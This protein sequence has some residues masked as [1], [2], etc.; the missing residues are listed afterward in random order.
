MKPR[1]I[2]L[3]I[4]IR[5]AG[6]LVFLLIV[7]C[8]CAFG[9]AGPANDNFSSRMTLTGTNVAITGSNVEATRE[10]GDTSVWWSWTAPT[11]AT[12]RASTSGSSFDTLDSNSHKRKQIIH[13]ARFPAG[14]HGE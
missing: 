7:P 5:C 9:A 8:R 13:R 10:L 6:F 1:R 3:G 12:V 14:R 2:D 4:V 11:T